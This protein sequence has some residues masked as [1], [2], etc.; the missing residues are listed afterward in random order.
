VGVYET[1]QLA[2]FGPALADR[3]QLVDGLKTPELLVV[4][5]TMPV[6]VVGLVEVSITL[7]VQLVATLMMTEPGEHV[8]T[9]VV[10]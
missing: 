5:S 8:T 7:A 6:G 4:K 9:V 3:M 10:G 1:E 2:I